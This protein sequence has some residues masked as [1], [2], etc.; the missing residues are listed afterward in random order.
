MDHLHDDLQ[1]LG[2]VKAA[3]EEVARRHSTPAAV[4]ERGNEGLHTDGSVHK[5]DA[6]VQEQ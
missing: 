3:I 2:L 5:G 4:R 1:L 6:L